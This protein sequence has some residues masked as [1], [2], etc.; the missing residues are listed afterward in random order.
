[1]LVVTN[2]EHSRH[3]PQVEFEQSAA[4]EPLEHPG[5]ADGIR[6]SLAADDRFELVAPVAH[7]DEVVTAVHEPGLVEFLRI[8][9]EEFQTVI[10]PAREVVPDVFAHAR[11]RAGMGPAA[12][13]SH[14]GGRLGW[15]CYETTTP[16]VEGT[17]AAARGAVDA[18]VT[19]AEL[20]LGGERATYALCRPPGHHASASLY[21]GYCFFNNAAIA[22]EHL[23]RRT[24]AKVA[25]LDV[26]YHHGN[27]T[28]QIFYERADIQYVSLHGDPARAYPYLV[29][30]AEET[31]AGA[32]LGATVNLPLPLGADDDTYLAALATALERIS[33]FGAELVV[34]SLGLDTASTDPI[35]DLAVTTDG[36]ARCGALVAEL[37]VPTLVVQEGGYDVGTLG[38]SV[39]RWLLGLSGRSGLQR[40]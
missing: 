10:G 37:G 27:G 6:R 26:D 36:F 12:E 20:L 1:M 19:A 34:V 24:G 13:P 28:Q 18:A 11:L 8:A 40:E 3:D 21:G 2:P 38:E 23:R 14:I 35:G 16:L 7:S 25:V 9:W 15:W 4:H 32:G 17:Y 39:R 31:G 33:A 22:A 5:R 29:G 30:F